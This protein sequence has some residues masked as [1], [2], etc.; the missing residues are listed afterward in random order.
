MKYYK[1]GYTTYGELKADGY[2]HIEL[3]GKDYLVHNL[4]AETFLNGN[5]PIPEGYVVRHKNGNTIDNR[6]DNL[7]IV[8][9]DD[10]I[11]GVD[12]E[13][14]TTAFDHFGCY[15]FYVDGELKV[16]ILFGDALEELDYAYE[17]FEDYQDI[18][19]ENGL[20]CLS[21]KK[22]DYPA[23]IEVVVEE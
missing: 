5:K 22:L 20:T 14:I 1:K 19:E 13:I 8:K 7:E 21:M 9:A 6:A 18:I 12:E 23:G 2:L 3:K 4:V 10:E 17:H 11:L 16:F 15:P